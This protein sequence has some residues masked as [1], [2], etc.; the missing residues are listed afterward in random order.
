MLDER[1]YLIEEFADAHRMVGAAVSDLTDEI[2]NRK[3][4]GTA[5]SIAALLAHAVVVEDL[6]V[7]RFFGGGDSL[8]ESGGWSEKTGIPASARDIWPGD[9]SL[10]VKA[11]D[12]YRLEVQKTTD[13]LMA[14]L[15]PALLDQEIQAFRNPRRGGQLLRV[16]GCNHIMGHLGE[17]SLLRGVNGLA[18]LP[19]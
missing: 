8:F 7:N 5:N 17:I 10:N 13:A 11:F 16:S 14:G 19:I 2:A 3:P 9:W 15:D 18:G 4:G 6:I 12:G 1:E